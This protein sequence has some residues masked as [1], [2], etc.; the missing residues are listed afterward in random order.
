MV[1][2]F[3]CSIVPCR[4][5]DAKAMPGTYRR[6]Q[7]LKKRPI[8][9]SFL[10]F[11]VTAAHKSCASNSTIPGDA[12]SSFPHFASP[13]KGIEDQQHRISDDAGNMKV[14]SLH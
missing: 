5:K 6:Y 9:D 3:F 12:L 4:D 14:A 11:P 1:K 10:R 7:G 8:A 2:L 13:P